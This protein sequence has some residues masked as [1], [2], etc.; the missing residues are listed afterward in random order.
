MFLSVLVVF[1]AM[2]D[3]ES[4]TSHL[5]RLIRS[6][7]TAEVLH[8]LSVMAFDPNVHIDFRF[9]AARTI[10]CSRSMARDGVVQA[11]MV[12][13]GR[14]VHYHEQRILMAL[15][16]KDKCSEAQRKYLVERALDNRSN[17]DSSLINS[18]LV[19]RSSTGFSDMTENAL[20]SIYLVGGKMALKTLNGLLPRVKSEK[21]LCEYYLQR[22]KY[23]PPK[24]KTTR[25]DGSI[26]YSKELRLPFR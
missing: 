6:P 20:R 4:V 1:V 26:Y 2:R 7:K 22:L 13:Y 3:V 17:S 10:A 9:G 16:D 12:K 25:P 24:W 18:T 15:V 11:L 21:G 23:G 14:S 5:R 19:R 8:E